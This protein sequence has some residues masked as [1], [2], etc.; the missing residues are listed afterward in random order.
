MKALFTGRWIAFTICSIVAFAVLLGLAQWQWS[1]AEAHK[2]VK[3][4]QVRP[5][6][7]VVSLTQGV[8]SD[9]PGSPVSVS[10]TYDASKQLRV[11]GQQVGNQSVDYVLTPITQADGVRVPIV[12]GYIPSGA[13]LPVPPSGPVSVVGVLQASQYYSGT[14]PDIEAVSTQNLAQRWSARLLDGYVVLRISTPSQTGLALLPASSIHTH[15]GL[16]VWR[17]IAYALQWLV[18]AGFVAFFWFRA[19]RDQVRAGT[20]APSEQAPQ[21]APPEPGAT[22]QPAGASESTN[23]GEL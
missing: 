21:G 11:T 3:S 18:F 7:Q 9:G 5:I 2:H 14:G 1:S 8:P 20:G 12:R 15:H 23:K 4:V 19:S 6:S 22:D 16:P 10:G 13:A 17:N